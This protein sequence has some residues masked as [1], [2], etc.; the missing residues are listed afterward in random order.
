[1]RAVLNAVI[2]G[3]EVELYAEGN[4]RLNAVNNALKEGLGLEYTLT[5]YEE[6]ALEGTSAARA[7][8]YVGLSWPDGTTSWGAGTDPDIIQS[9]INALVSA[10]NNHFRG[11][12][13]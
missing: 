11:E 3:R 6:H 4:G 5:T 7:A 8:G 12:E 1:M 9:G 13:D 10:I 2:N